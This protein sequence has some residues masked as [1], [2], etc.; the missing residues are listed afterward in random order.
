MRSE[1]EMPSHY[2]DGIYCFYYFILGMVIN[3]P[4]T[5]IKLANQAVRIGSIAPFLPN[6]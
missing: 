5:K 4:T 3:V 2:W 1:I 6:A